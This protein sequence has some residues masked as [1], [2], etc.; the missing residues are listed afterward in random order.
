[1]TTIKQE[2][3][4]KCGGELEYD[5]GSNMENETWACVDCHTFFD[6]QIEVVRNWST[7]EEI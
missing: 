1:M 3:C 7:L 6:V 5:N 4:P 2:D